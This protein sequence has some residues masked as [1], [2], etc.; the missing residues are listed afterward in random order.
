MTDAGSHVPLSM[1]YIKSSE[2]VCEA[3]VGVLFATLLSLAVELVLNSSSESP[4]DLS[5]VGEVRGFHIEEEELSR[6]LFKHPEESASI[7]VVV[8]DGCLMVD[9]RFVDLI[10]LWFAQRSQV[11][12]FSKL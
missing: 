12:E 8:N 3:V 11:E 7:C 2:A 1:E 10:F 4:V 5:R 9:Y 6:L